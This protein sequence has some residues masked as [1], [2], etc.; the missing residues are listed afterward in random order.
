M[1]I[2]RDALEDCQRGTWRLLEKQVE[3]DGY[4]RR[5]VSSEK[6]VERDRG[7]RRE[8]RRERQVV[9]GCGGVCHVGLLSQSV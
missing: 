9:C 8:A 2:A 5:W 7:S 3:R 1:E 4:N 6:Q